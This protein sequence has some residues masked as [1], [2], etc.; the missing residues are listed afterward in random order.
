MARTYEV[1]VSIP[2]S[3]YCSTKVEEILYFQTSK[4]SGTCTAFP[5][6]NGYLLAMDRDKGFQLSSPE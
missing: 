1:A 3:G 6:E 5:F 2:V 4:S